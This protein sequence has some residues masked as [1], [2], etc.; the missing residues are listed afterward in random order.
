MHAAFFQPPFPGSRCV[1]FFFGGGRSVLGKV[2]GVMVKFGIPDPKDVIF[3]VVTEI[4]GGG[5]CWY[6]WDG[7][8]KKNQPHIH[9]I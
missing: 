6:P 1:F 3:L 5:K 8:L 4:Q 9:L 2:Q 7:T